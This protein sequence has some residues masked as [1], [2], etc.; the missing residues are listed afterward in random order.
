MTHLADKLKLLTTGTQALAQQIEAKADA[1][2]AKQAQ[3]ADRANAIMS[4]QDA[5]MA[6][7]EAGIAEM[8]KVLGSVTNAA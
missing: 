8:E 7:A 6:D 3:L 5:L 1:A 2:L 4:T